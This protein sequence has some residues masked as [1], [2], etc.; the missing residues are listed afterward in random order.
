MAIVSLADRLT[1]LDPAKRHAYIS[2]RRIACHVSDLDV[3]YQ[4][5]LH[6][7]GLDFLPSSDSSPVQM[8]ITLN[9]DDL[10]ALADGELRFSQAW[11]GGRA[12]IE[13]SVRD[14]LRLR[15]LL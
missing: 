3:A 10:V 9:S 13:A 15:H 7:E 2:E 4:M 11:L 6:P 8:S 12:K 14:L 1:K 5:R